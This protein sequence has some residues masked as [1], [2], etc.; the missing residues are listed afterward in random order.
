MRERRPA[1]FQGCASGGAGARGAWVARER[2]SSTVRVARER[3]RFGTRMKQGHLKPCA[4]CAG[5]CADPKQACSDFQ[6]NRTPTSPRTPGCVHSPSAASRLASSG[7]SPPD[8]AHRHRGRSSTT[9]AANYPE[10][11]C[12]QK[13]SAPWG[14]WNRM[15]RGSAEC[16]DVRSRPPSQTAQADTADRRR[17]SHT[18][19]KRQGL[20]GRQA[21]AGRGGPSE[22]VAAPCRGGPQ[23]SNLREA[24]HTRSAAA[25][26]VATAAPLRHVE[27]WPWDDGD[28][29]RPQ[30][31]RN[32]RHTAPSSGGAR[33]VLCIVAATCSWGAAQRSRRCIDCE[34]TGIRP[35]GGVLRPPAK[36]RRLQR[37]S[38]LRGVHHQ[39][40]SAASLQTAAPPLGGFPT[41]SVLNHRNEAVQGGHHGIGPCRVPEGPVCSRDLFRKGFVCV[42]VWHA[43]RPLDPLS[44]ALVD[45]SAKLAVYSYSLSGRCRERCRRRPGRPRVEGSREC[46]SSRGSSRRSP[47]G[48]AQ[49]QEQHRWPPVCG[50]RAGRSWI[51]KRH[52]EARQRRS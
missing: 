10:A 38:A 42:C 14:K 8:G 48:S 9:F 13:A 6:T 36:P 31:A 47:L 37:R 41:P 40:L 52:L 7:R 51:R 2:R 29:C 4:R 21:S 19:P 1:G 5:A 50:P 26:A 45:A 17:A 34:S 39:P 33:A 44:L 11:P 23:A 35:G 12:A 49:R 27:R 3:R 30:G 22:G 46:G 28:T 15:G 24:V 18:R 32:C 16:V 25:E 20:H 43:R